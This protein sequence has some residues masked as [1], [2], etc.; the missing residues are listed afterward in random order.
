MIEVTPLLRRT[1]INI[2]THFYDRIKERKLDEATVVATLIVAAK[3]YYC[4]ILFDLELHGGCYIVSKNF[5]IALSHGKVPVATTVYK[6]TK[7]LDK[8]KYF[9]DL[10][11]DRQNGK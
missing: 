6:G 4:Q 1:P 11:K 2:S 9:V 7:T 3:Q 5:V 10:L 8:K